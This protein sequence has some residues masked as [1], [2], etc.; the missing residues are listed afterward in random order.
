MKTNYFVTITVLAL[1]IAL[2]TACSFENKNENS[3]ESKHLIYESGVVSQHIG[4]SLNTTSLPTG[5]RFRKELKIESGEGMVYEIPVYVLKGKNE[6]VLLEI[7][8]EYNYRTDS[9]DD[10]TIGE[11]EIFTDIFKTKNG[12][13]VGSTLE[14]FVEV[15]PDY[16]LK[17]IAEPNLFVVTT[18]SISGYFKLPSESFIS[19]INP[20]NEADR[21]MW[22]LEKEEFDSEARIETIT[23]RD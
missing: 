3:E 14:K 10:S 18:D 23:L 15:Y 13:G 8:P 9:Y 12:I 6:E 17:F 19:K 4:F 11:I 22:V 5:W 7:T 1:F 21:L 2:F 20:N 16:E